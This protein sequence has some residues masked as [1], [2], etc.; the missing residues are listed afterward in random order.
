MINELR[1]EAPK[2]LEAAIALLGS[3][4]GLS[5]ILAGGSDLLVQ[6][7]SGRVEPALIVD[8]KG[9]PELTTICAEKGGFRV[10]AAASC[11]SVIEHAAFT[12][13]WPGVSEAI[14]LIGSIQIKGRASVGGNLCNAS[15]AGDTIPALIE[16]ARARAS[17]GEMTDSLAKVWGRFQPN[18]EYGEP[19]PQLTE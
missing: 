17:I 13:T 8:V 19:V 10:G 9:I 14:A 7:R 5:R 12:K 15:P 18:V 6:M 4:E 16:A 11:M 2:T 3:A 1:Y